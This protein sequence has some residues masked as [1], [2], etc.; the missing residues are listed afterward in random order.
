MLS[1]L[2]NPLL[3]RPFPSHELQPPIS[4]HLA[5]EHQELTLSILMPPS[6]CVEWVTLTAGNTISSPLKRRYVP[7]S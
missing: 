5:D 7:H 2:Q 4:E 1:D 6:I 3:E